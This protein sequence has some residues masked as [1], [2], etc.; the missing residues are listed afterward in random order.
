MLVEKKDKISAGRTEIHWVF[1]LEVA[2]D[3]V[4]LGD[5]FLSTISPFRPH[6]GV[7]TSPAQAPRGPYRQ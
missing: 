2:L 7:R 4:F 1:K 3:F 5:V 6:F